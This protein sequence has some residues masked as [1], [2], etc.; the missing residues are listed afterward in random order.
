M[1]DEEKAKAEKLL[2]AKKRV[3][4][5]PTECSLKH[6]ADTSTTSRSTR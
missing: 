6:I 4:A 1:A 3:G 5:W 2:A